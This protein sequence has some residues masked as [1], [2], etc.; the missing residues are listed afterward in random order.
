MVNINRNFWQKLTFLTKTD[1][2]W[3]KIEFLIYS[4]FS[5][6][7]CLRGARTCIQ[8]WPLKGFFKIRILTTISIKFPIRAY[9]WK[10]TKNNIWGCFLGTTRCWFFACIF[11]IFF[12]RKKIDFRQNFFCILFFP[13]N[14]GNWCRRIRKSWSQVPKMTSSPD[15]SWF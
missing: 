4:K 11:L 2:F 9:L 5:T 7:S 8:M 1:I 12:R 6:K 15:F 14:R 13:G 10:L 3:Q